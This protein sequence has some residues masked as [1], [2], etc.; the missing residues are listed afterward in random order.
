MNFNWHLLVNSKM[1][2]NVKSTEF[3]PSTDK[4]I[5]FFFQSDAKVIRPRKKVECEN[6]STGH[7]L[8]F[9]LSDRTSLTIFIDRS[10]EINVFNRGKDSFRFKEKLVYPTDDKTRLY[11]YMLTISIDDNCYPQHC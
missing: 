7:Q 1:C 5:F 8:W 9:L 3:E 11:I 4:Q 2:E 6:T 10:M